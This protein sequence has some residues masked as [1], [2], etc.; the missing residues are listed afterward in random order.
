MA[1]VSTTRWVS[2]SPYVKLTV[3][4]DSSTETTST[5]SW[6][7]QYISDY[8][9][10]ASSRDYTVK[11]NGSSVKSGSYNIDGVTGT[12]TVAS[13]T[14]KITKTHSKQSIS[15]SVSFDM[16][17]TWSG[18]YKGTVSASGS[19]S[20]PAKT[21]YKVSY[22]ANGGSGA[23]SNQTKWHGEDSTISN[24]IPTRIGYDFSGWSVPGRDYDDVYYTPGSRNGYNGNQTLYAVWNAKTYTITYNAN[25]G[26]GAPTSQSYQY[27]STGS[28]NLSNVAPTRVGYNFLGW[29]LSS[30][31]TVRTYY[32]GQAWL[33]SNTSNYTLYAVWEL[34][35]FTI[36]YNANGGVSAP[37]SQT[38]TYGVNINVS[39]SQPTRSGYKFLG[40]ST[41]SGDETPMYLSGVTF[42]SNADTTL[43]AIWEQLGIA[44]I[45]VNGTFQ[46]GKV[47]VNDNGT[48]M[49]GIIFVN[50]NG[51]WTQGG[52]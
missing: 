41:N 36:S 10:N 45:N 24:T 17:I 43:Y 20:I 6:K 18:S 40:W 51:T 13:G 50:D 27:A 42:T 38:K 15:F 12:K 44:Y 37:D 34:K 25:G 22:N 4:E 32:S 19:I 7:L 9:A 30:T 3:T 31:A 35:K 46:A 5:L 1:S 48:W 39:T 14:K 16:K 33:R 29:S 21:S 28:I 47:W 8:A 49:T 11:I 2:T 26:T 52:I 23:P